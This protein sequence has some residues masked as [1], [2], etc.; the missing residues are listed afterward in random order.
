MAKDVMGR[1]IEIKLQTQHKFIASA[2]QRDVPLSMGNTKCD[3]SRV[4]GTKQDAQTCTARNEGF[5]PANCL[6][7]T[8][9]FCGV[10]AARCA[11]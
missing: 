3:T 4:F 2:G 10:V 7:K 1:N 9:E 11:P 5:G 8:N 6:S